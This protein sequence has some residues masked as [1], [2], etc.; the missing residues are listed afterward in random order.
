MKTIKWFCGRCRNIS[1]RTCEEDFLK[2]FN[3]KMFLKNSMYPMKYLLTY[4]LLS[5]DS[6][7]SFF[8]ENCLQK[9]QPKYFSGL[10]T[11][12]DKDKK[13]KGLTQSL[14]KCTSFHWSLQGQKIVAPFKSLFEAYS[15]WK[16]HPIIGLLYS[17]YHISIQR[18]ATCIQAW[19]LQKTPFPETVSDVLSHTRPSQGPL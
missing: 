2:F 11:P 14:Q 18:L 16:R 4:V 15:N 3:L 9:I 17:L 10:K 7:K 1:F 5:A 6:Y 19:V 8:D 13:D 12:R